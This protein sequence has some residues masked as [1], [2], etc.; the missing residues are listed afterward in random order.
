[1]LQ[2][3]KSNNLKIVLTSNEVMQLFGGQGINLKDAKTRKVMDKILSRAA[4]KMHFELNSAKNLVEIF[5]KSN[6]TCVI[7]FI[8]VCQNL[9]REAVLEFENVDDLITAAVQLKD[10]RLS[11]YCYK[12]NYRIIASIN[13]VSDKIIKRLCELSKIRYDSE[14]VA[15]TKEYGVRKF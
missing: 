9:Q 13:A 12:G 8:N 3:I 4:E 10:T 5:K 7:Y 2:I 11:G 14:E 6:G 15:R 1:M